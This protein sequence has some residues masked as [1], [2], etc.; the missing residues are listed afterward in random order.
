MK[1]FL[2]ALWLYAGSVALA[3][4]S[5]TDVLYKVDHS[6]INVKIDELTDTDVVYFESTAPTV[7]KTVTRSQIWKIVFR[8]GSTEVITA[9]PGKTATT[10]QITLVDRTI[11][12]GKV[13]QRDERKLYYTKASDPTNTQ[14]ELL[15]TRL[16]RIR[17]V[18][19]REEIFRQAVVSKQPKGPSRAD[20]EAP[21]KTTPAPVPTDDLSTG[22][23][24]A[25]YKDPMAFPH[26][27]LTVGP[28]F[29]YYPNALNANRAWLDDSTGFGMKQ[30]IGFSLRLDYLLFR[31][32]GASLTAGYYGWELVRRYTRDGVDQYSETKR[33]TQVPIQLG[34][35]L[36][37]FGSFYVMPEAGATLAFASVNTS[38]NHP[39]PADESV[40]STPITYGGSL[41]YE[42]RSK[43]LLLDL[44]LRYQL[45]NVKNL[46][47][48]AFRQ[49]LN[50]QVNIASF[51]IGIGFNALKK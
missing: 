22:S 31:R 49:S 34:L 50:E 27:H 36:Y 25:S 6:T 11:I 21:V 18:D 19:G 37:P 45:L 3:Q 38:A 43:A 46:N 51:R 14:Y 1:T 26:L 28:E 41:G 39:T 33:L 20:N 24:T 2:F 32:L 8:D 29:A 5:P 48:T 35:K 15:L 17:Y 16:D 13:G 23:A 10:D 30:N 7:K 44:S 9:Q 42:I 12:N 47:Y 4:T 40:R